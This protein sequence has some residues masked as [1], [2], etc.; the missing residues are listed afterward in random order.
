MWQSEDDDYSQ[1]YLT[2]EGI[3]ALLLAT[4]FYTISMASRGKYSLSH[5]VFFRD[6]HMYQPPRAIGSSPSTKQRNSHPYDHQRD[7]ISSSI[8]SNLQFKIL[9]PGQVACTAMKNH[10]TTVLWKCMEATS[11]WIVACFVA[12]CLRWVRH[13]LFW[14]FSNCCPQNNSCWR[15]ILKREDATKPILVLLFAICVVYQGIVP[16]SRR[17]LQMPPGSS[18]RYSPSSYIVGGVWLVAL[19]AGASQVYLTTSAE[20]AAARILLAFRV[21]GIRIKDERTVYHNI[22]YI[23]RSAFVIAIAWIGFL[24]SESIS[25]SLQLYFYQFQLELH[26]M[27]WNPFSLPSR[28]ISS[29]SITVQTSNGTN[30]TP[31]YSLRSWFRVFAILIPMLLLPSLILTCIWINLTSFQIILTWIWILLL[32][33]NIRPLLQLH[34]NRAIPIVQKLLVLNRELTQE[35][36]SSPF[37]Y[38]FKTLLDSS[39]KLSVFPHAMIVLLSYTTFCRSSQ[40]IYPVPYGSPLGVN[41]TNAFWGNKANNVY[42]TRQ[43]TPLS[44]FLED[45]PCESESVSFSSTQVFHLPNIQRGSELLDYAPQVPMTLAQILRDLQSPPKLETSTT[46]SKRFVLTSLWNHPI[47]TST[48]GKPILTLLTVFILSWWLLVFAYMTLSGNNN[49]EEFDSFKS[50]NELRSKST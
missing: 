19:T 28:L 6:L 29:P 24:L 38:R 23:L 4:S 39:I 49:K 40:S 41:S 32:Y 33:A 37:Q 17:T 14:I 50:I 47:I 30:K 5:A 9:A 25:T 31:W 26:S 7:G 10:E 48:V 46:L 21:I 18:L 13:S 34:L 22:A 45:P 11:A 36:L 20:E 43:K 35:E 42:Y 3:L 2:W 44:L 1:V 16:L 15:E 8:F 27:S 12:Y